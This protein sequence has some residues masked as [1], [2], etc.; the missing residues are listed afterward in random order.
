MNHRE[1]ECDP[2]I[3]VILSEWQGN[4]VYR[5]IKQTLFPEP[6]L[7]LI[8]D[9]LPF[10][11]YVGY[12]CDRVVMIHFLFDSDC[13]WWWSFDKRLSM[14]TPNPTKILFVDGGGDGDQVTVYDYSGKIREDFLRS[15][16]YCWC[17]LCVK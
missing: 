16:N 11:H 6:M 5:V 4:E 12:G 13:N 1:L 15:L 8:K 7:G 17:S 3:Q 9:L 14:K 10:V 2:L